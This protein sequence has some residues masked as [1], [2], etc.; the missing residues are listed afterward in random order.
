M[1]KFI[2][3][4]GN[5]WVSKVKGEKDEKTGHICAIKTI[6]LTS[7]KSKSMQFDNHHGAKSVANRIKSY[8][9]VVQV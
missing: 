3:T 6:E 5:M 9:A 1:E 7:D 2:V 8:G 4:V